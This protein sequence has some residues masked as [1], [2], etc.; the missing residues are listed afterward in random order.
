MKNKKKIL[1]LIACLSLLSSC[2]KTNPSNKSCSVTN[3]TPTTVNPTPTPEHIPSKS[4][5]ELNKELFENYAIINSSNSL[6]DFK[7]NIP[8][9]YLNL[10]IL[11]IPETVNNVK[12][13][14]ITARW[15][16]NFF[17]VY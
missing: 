2:N 16:R 1:S 12:L 10:K 6:I 8:E 14:S 7:D 11:I 15:R 4:D 13:T 17:Y 3:S 5:E 9:E